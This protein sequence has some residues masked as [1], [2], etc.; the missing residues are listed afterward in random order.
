MEGADPAGDS[1]LPRGGSLRGIASD[2][3]GDLKN[4]LKQELEPKGPPILLF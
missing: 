1:H 4:E 3:F 2:P